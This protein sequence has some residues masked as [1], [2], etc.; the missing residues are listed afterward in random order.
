MIFCYKTNTKHDV[1]YIVFVKKINKK[2]VD[3]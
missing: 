2:K 3:K 1:A